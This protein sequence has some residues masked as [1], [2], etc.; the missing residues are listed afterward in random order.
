[1]SHVRVG[2][3]R[4]ER[5]YP[6]AI[7]QTLD[8]VCPMLCKS[9]HKLAAFASILGH[10]MHIKNNGPLISSTSYWDSEQANA[11]YAYL[12]FNAGAARMLI[13]NSM[14]EF[15]DDTA[16]ATRVSLQTVGAAL[17]GLNHLVFEDDS[18]DPYF[19]SLDARQMDRTL[20]VGSVGQWI[21][22]LIYSDAPRGQVQLRRSLSAIIAATTSVWPDSSA[23]PP[24][25][26]DVRALAGSLRRAGI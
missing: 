5:A 19:V 21:P 1:M 23:V 25:P 15:F 4:S 17:A 20:P 9:G 11:G 18:P 14:K 12:S 7:R 2:P 10:H 3:A 26:E 8:R 16:T 24:A 13:P 6:G 22:L